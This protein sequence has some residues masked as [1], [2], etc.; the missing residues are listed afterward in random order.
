MDSVLPNKPLAGLSLLVAEDDAMAALLVCEVLREQ[1]AWVIHAEDGQRAL[2][3]FHQDEFDLVISDIH[4]P[5]LTG[6]ELL[7]ALRSESGV[8]LIGLSGDAHDL[9]GRTL[10]EAGALTVLSK[11]LDLKRL[12]LVLKENGLIPTQAL[13]NQS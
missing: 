12:I 10:L 11:P 1:G 3:A 8:P 5:K 13:S 9:D 7:I 4:M 2:E 6:I